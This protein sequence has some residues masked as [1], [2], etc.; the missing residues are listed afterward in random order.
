MGNRINNIIKK[1]I[2]YDLPDDYLYQTNDKGLV[3]TYTY[4]GPDKIWVFVNN[5]T[6]KLTN[7][8]FYTERD[9]GD[10]IPIPENQTKVC[11][12][13]DNDPVIISM[14]YRVNY[15]GP[16]KK[17]NLP[18]GSV[19]ERPDPTPPDHTYELM[20]CE[21]DITNQKW[22]TPLPWKKPHMDWETLKMARNNML[23]ESDFLIRNNI[24]TAEQSI[25]LEE[26]RQ[27]LR[28]LPDVFSGIDPWKVPFPQLPKIGGNN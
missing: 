6:G 18:D 5:E 1:K 12:T 11:V 26:Y 21:Y 15:E 10:Q 24:L 22:K 2:N 27:K 23:R 9:D 20:E 19:Y 4:E 13:A 7:G 17:E 28:D 14:I 25:A 16:N 8:V 3:G